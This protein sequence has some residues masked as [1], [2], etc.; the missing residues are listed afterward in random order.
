MYIFEQKSEE[1]NE[2]FICFEVS[3]EHEK[4]PSRLN[5]HIN[6]IKSCQCDGWIHNDC[7]ETWYNMHGKCPI[8]CVKITYL[9]FEYHYLFY[10]MNYFI[11][12]GNINIFFQYIIKIRNFLIFCIIISNI[13]NILNNF[14]EIEYEYISYNNYCYPLND[15]N[16]LTDI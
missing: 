14:D 12:F 16:L 7:I 6:F 9:K 3:N 1:A 5:D 10:I 4:K 8:C 11:I 13:L 15:N 2:C